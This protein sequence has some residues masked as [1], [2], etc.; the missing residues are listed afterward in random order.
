MGR[1]RKS[2]LDVLA[3]LPWPVGVVAG[4][5]G[6]LLVRYGFTGW[7]SRAGGPLTQGLAD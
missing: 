1:R 7:M 3:E 4:V 6:Y 2:G 5:L